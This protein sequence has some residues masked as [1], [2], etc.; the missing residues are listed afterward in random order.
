VRLFGGPKR[1]FEIENCFLKYPTG[2]TIS[3]KYKVN[4]EIGLG[5]YLLEIPMLVADISDDC[6]LGTDFLEKVKLDKIFE[7]EFGKP[8]KE[9]GNEFSCSRILFSVHK[10]TNLKS[11]YIDWFKYHSIYF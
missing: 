7:S 4:V 8:E 3:V 10:N 6:I 5:K 9:S 1:C 2:E 11:I